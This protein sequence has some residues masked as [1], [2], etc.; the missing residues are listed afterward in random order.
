MAKADLRNGSNICSETYVNYFNVLLQTPNQVCVQIIRKRLSGMSDSRSFPRVTP[1]PNGESFHHAQPSL[2]HR[3]FCFWHLTLLA[4]SMRRSYLSWMNECPRM[5]R[6][7]HRRSERIKAVLLVL[8]DM[9]V[10]T[11]AD[12]FTLIVLFQCTRGFQAFPHLP[13]RR[14][15][16]PASVNAWF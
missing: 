4:H 3:A 1:H 10:S 13:R 14:Y 5:I 11:V 8:V 16:W 15:Q 7:N 6:I 2:R 12:G 9:K